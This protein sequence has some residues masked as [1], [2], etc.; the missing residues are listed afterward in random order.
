LVLNLNLMTSL[1][2]ADLFNLLI[3]V[4]A[5]TALTFKLS[6]RDAVYSETI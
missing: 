5:D 4:H 1:A 3:L 2:S 6:E